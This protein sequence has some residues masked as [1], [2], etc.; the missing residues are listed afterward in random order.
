MKAIREAAAAAGIDLNQFETTGELLDRLV[1]DLRGTKPTQS[2][3]HGELPSG[4]SSNPARLP[5]SAVE[6]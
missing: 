6:K 3:A 4:Q 1:I 2:A 5:E